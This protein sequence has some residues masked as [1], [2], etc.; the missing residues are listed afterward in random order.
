MTRKRIRDRI[1][2]G[3]RIEKGEIP[4]GTHDAVGRHGSTS[5]TTSTAGGSTRATTS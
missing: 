4:D 2:A 1:D 5:P 3:M